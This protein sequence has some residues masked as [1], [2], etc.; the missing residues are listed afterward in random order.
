MNRD[1]KIYDKLLSAHQLFDDKK[2]TSNKETA[3]KELHPDIDRMR[4]VA[5]LCK[6][7]GIKHIVIASGTRH[8]SLVRYFEEN[9][10]FK[11]YYSTDERS[12]GFFAIGIALKLKC[13]VAVCCTSGT[14]T[15]NLLSPITEAYYQNV[16]LVAITADRYPCLLNQMDPQHI[17]QSNMYQNVVKKSVTLPVGDSYSAKWEARR[18]VQ[19]ALLEVNHNGLGPVHINIPVAYIERLPPK[20]ETLTLGQYKHMTRITLHENDKPLWEKSAQILKGKRILMLFE[21]ST[22]FSEKE[23]QLINKFI[24]KYN[25]VVIG[26]NLTNLHIEKRFHP[27]PFFSKY[28]PQTIADNLAPQVVITIG[29]NTLIGLGGVLSKVPDFYHWRVSEDGKIADPFKKLR[30]V[31]ECSLSEFLTRMCE[32]DNPGQDTNEYYNKWKS[33]DD[34][35]P[36]KTVNTFCMEYSILELLN[37]LPQNSLLHLANSSTVRYANNIRIRNDIEVFCN[38]GTNGIDGSMS[39]FLGQAAVSKE[40]CFLIIG[41]LSFFYDM[42]SLWNKKLNGNI[43]IMLI[44]NKKAKLLEHHKSPSIT[45]AHNTSAKGWVESLNMTYLSATT[46]SEFDENIKRFVSDENVP[47]F[48]EILTDI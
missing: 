19:E 23:E 38:R 34:K 46:K 1:S 39:T 24:S 36:P 6:D 8:I 17:P 30:R 18:L 35:I 15:S 37:K 33:F 48:F 31:F 45:Q 11:T 22:G 3:K 16:P 10:Y 29:D 28:G 7:Y 32:Y 14:A 2:E 27:I 41:D 26:D 40:M 12:A 43:R 13:P 42:N 44:N 9:S 21:Q 25:C 4:M 5:S 20:K 47:M